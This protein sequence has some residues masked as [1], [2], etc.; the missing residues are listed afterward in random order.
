MNIKIKLILILRIYISIMQNQL[1]LNNLISIKIIKTF[2][3]QNTHFFK[4][5][6]P[7]YL[8]NLLTIFSITKLSKYFDI[9]N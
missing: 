7:I 2:S 6:Y 1:Y 5:N 3:I 4:L 8:I 9:Y